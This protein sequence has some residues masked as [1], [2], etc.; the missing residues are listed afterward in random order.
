LPTLI[1]PPPL[2]RRHAVTPRFSALTPPL[3]FSRHYAA[4]YR[5]SIFR[6]AIDRYTLPL[7]HIAASAIIFA[8]H[9]ATATLTLIRH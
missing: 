2:S 9:Y 6:A 8:M 3:A 7:R 5:C 4:A 1:S